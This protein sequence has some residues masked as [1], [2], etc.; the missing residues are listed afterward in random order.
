VNDQTSS[1]GDDTGI[2]WRLAG[3]ILTALAALF[4]LQ[5]LGFRFV[6]AYGSA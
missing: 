4:I 1:T 2:A 5:R 6:V 3:F